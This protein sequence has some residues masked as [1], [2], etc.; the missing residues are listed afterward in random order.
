MT[1]PRRRNDPPEE[2]NPDSRAAG[3]APVAFAP[4]EHRRT[5]PLQGFT[6]PSLK[7]VGGRPRG[8]RTLMRNR[9][10]LRLWLAQLISQTI[11]N[12]ANYALIIVTQRSGS[13]SFTAAAG[14]IVAF[15]LPA[16]LFGAPAGVLV[17]RFDRRLV[18]WT[19]NLLRA[20]ASVVF[21]VV[22]MLDSTPLLPVYIL[23]FFI[24]LV[25]QFFAP[26]E[27]AAI[28]L[29][30]GREEMI[31]A[32]SLFNITFT[33]AQAAGLIILGPLMLALVPTI[34]IG[35]ATH[36]IDFTSRETLFIVIALLY[37]VCVG[38][39]LSI[40]KSR[41]KVTQQSHNQQDVL[42]ASSDMSQIRRVYVSIL[43]TGNFIR[44]D[45]RLLIS[46]GQLAL[47]G[48][49]VAVIAMIAPGFVEE[50]F[51]KPPEL[52]AIVFVPAGAGLVLGSAITPNVARWLG[53]TR[54]IAVGVIMLA[55]SAALLAGGRAVAPHIFGAQTFYDAPLYLVAVMFLTF[56]IGIGLDF[57]NVPAQTMLQDRSPN[58]IKGRVLAVQ[59]M[60]LNAVTIPFVLVMGRIADGY[61]LS[62]AI[63]VLA[64][65]IGSAG[66]LSVYLG[67]R[68]DPEERQPAS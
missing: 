23:A 11:M 60:V 15:S 52:A 29:L 16:L 51:H 35:T 18:L 62:P 6:D 38:L 67:S 47:G 25:G 49:V 65:I 8:F 50:F 58:W 41:M 31:H 57:V 28:P 13:G 27:G 45:R 53:Y 64:G 44:K 1:N 21:V 46:V 42:F 43:Q 33:L 54:T 40:P 24:A 68:P 56:L 2:Q 19:S 30:V 3:V 55:G 59:A 12:A 9:Y 17:D 37:M 63:L 26:A 14:A 5:G 36:G 20:I 48:S 4:N 66:L 22:L 39:I 61:G 34:H 7:A 10:F 32:L